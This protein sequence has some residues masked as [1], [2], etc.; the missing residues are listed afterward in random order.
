VIFI[1]DD[2]WQPHPTHVMTDWKST[3]VTIIA[4]ARFGELRMCKNCEAEE[5]RTV[6][7]HAC[8]DELKEPC[9]FPEDNP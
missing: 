2:N 3:I 4:T 9:P 7:G 5:A 6:S 8:H 1:H